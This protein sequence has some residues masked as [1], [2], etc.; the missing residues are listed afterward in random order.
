MSVL[1]KKPTI[2]EVIE[3]IAE[4]GLIFELNN[5]LNGETTAY[6]ISTDKTITYTPSDNEVLIKDTS[7]NG[8]VDAFKNSLNGV[9]LIYELAIPTTEQYM[10]LHLP[11]EIKYAKTSEMD[12]EINK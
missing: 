12:L 11:K 6:N 7:F 8:D 2:N 10:S 3:E 5:I 9:K 4:K 1:Y